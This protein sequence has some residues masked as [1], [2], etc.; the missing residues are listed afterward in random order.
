ML[1]NYLT[2]IAHE[3]LETVHSKHHMC[4]RETNENSIIDVTSFMA[5]IE[6]WMSEGPI[7][8][9]PDI[10]QKQTACTCICW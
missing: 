10:A 9:F 5:D 8:K 2:V 6:M 3:N 7:W 1:E 4:S